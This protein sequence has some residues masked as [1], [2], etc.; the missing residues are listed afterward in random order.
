MTFQEPWRQ[1]PISNL[2][3]RMPH[4]S[5]GG[6][7]AK[8]RGLEMLCI[9]SYRTC[10][11]HVL[12]LSLPLSRCLSL[13]SSNTDAEL[14]M[15][16]QGLYGGLLGKCGRRQT[17]RQQHTLGRAHRRKLL[18]DPAKSLE[19]KPYCRDVCLQAVEGTII[20]MSYLSW[21][22]A[23]GVG[24]QRTSVALPCF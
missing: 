6:C 10:P 13:E 18:L 23:C 22:R 4:R 3:K 14:K 7:F 12:P 16:V 2:S 20:F 8:D 1:H 17:D 5:C 19:Y 9:A 24:V 21:V 11:D 15:C